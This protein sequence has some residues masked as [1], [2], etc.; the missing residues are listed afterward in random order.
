MSL[1]KIEKH[2]YYL[3]IKNNNTNLKFKYYIEINLY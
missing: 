3:F 1:K 2:R